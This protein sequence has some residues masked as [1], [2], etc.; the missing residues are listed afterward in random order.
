MNNPQGLR[1]AVVR[2]TQV[3]LLLGTGRTQAW[4][5]TKAADFP[6]PI[7]LGAKA[8]GYLV[9]EVLSWLSTRAPRVSAKGDRLGLIPEVAQGEDGRVEAVPGE[10]QRNAG[11]SSP[12]TAPP[13]SPDPVAAGAVGTLAAPIGSSHDPRRR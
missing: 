6:T 2:S 12:A 13:P 1:P 5:I 3:H 4:K 8:K 10:T 11:K 7:R 9:D